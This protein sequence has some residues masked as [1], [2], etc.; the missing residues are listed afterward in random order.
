MK[1]LAAFPA[2]KSIRIVDH[3]RP[4]ITSPT[5]VRLRVIEVGVCGTDREIARFD[6]GTPPDGCDHLVIGHESL[7][8]VV[9]VGTGVTDLAV[10]DLVVPMVRRPCPHPTCPACRVGRQDFC[11]TGDFTERGIKGRHGFLTEEVVDD[12]RYMNRVPR[13]LRHTG[14]LVEPLTIAEKALLQLWQ[15]QQRLPWA[16][17]VEPG[18]ASGHCHTA[19]VLGAGPVG[20]LGALALATADFD[21]WVY[22][23]KP[24]PN[25][26]STLLA[27]AGI[28]YVSST[29]ETIAALAERL[30][31]IDVVYEATGAA[32]VAFETLAVMGTNSVFV[33]TGVPG[34]R[35]P[36]EVEADAL[37]RNMVLRNQLVFGTVNASHE[38][39]AN[40][41][42]DLGVFEQRWPGV[43]QQLITGRFPMEAHEQLLRGESTG[44]K[45]VIAL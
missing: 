14:I 15:V 7:G 32:S 2:S 37:M 36:I 34:R 25:P 21:T 39:F 8:E 3:E 17:P 33:F 12:V 23:R 22:S 19:V 29:D 28:R 4:R 5:E 16:C 40:A 42:R 10:G 38:A 1:A 6:Y 44:I 9:E 41:I 43:T 30:G 24:A 11:Y 35:G 18:K 13:E 20:L 31:N 26:V 45:N 27:T